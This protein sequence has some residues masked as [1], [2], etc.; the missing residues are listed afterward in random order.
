[1][2]RSE[3]SPSPGLIR[4]SLSAIRLPF[5]IRHLAEILSNEAAA[6]QEVINRVRSGVGT[7]LFLF[8]GGYLHWGLYGY[9]LSALLKGDVPVYLLHSVLDSISKSKRSKTWSQMVQYGWQ[10]SA[11]AGM[12]LLNW[13]TSSKAVGA[14][15]NLLS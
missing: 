12:R 15:S 5:T 2:D 13:L 1:M 10:P 14:Q 8:H 6:K 3:D 9:R 7:P 4:S 11:T